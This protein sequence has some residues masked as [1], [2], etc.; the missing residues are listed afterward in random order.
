[1]KLHSGKITVIKTC[2]MSEFNHIFSSVPSPAHFFKTFTNMHFQYIWDN[3]PDKIKCIQISQN[4][5]N[6]CPR[7]VNVENFVHSKTDL[8]K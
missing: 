5:M 6:G 8:G 3:R 4:Y 1:M 2:I 7:M